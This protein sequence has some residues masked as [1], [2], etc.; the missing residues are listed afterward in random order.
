MQVFFYAVIYTEFCILIFDPYLKG[1]NEM[2]HR[3]L[4]VILLCI[5]PCASAQP[6][7][8]TRVFGSPAPGWEFVYSHDLGGP[9]N[10]FTVTS[11]NFQGFNGFEFDRPRDR[12]VMIGTETGSARLISVDP[13]FDPASQILLRTGLDESA[14]GVDVDPDTGRIYWWENDEILSVN[15]DGTGTPIVEADNVPEPLLLEID[16]SRGF[17]VMLDY[18]A[19]DLVVGQLNG[20]SSPA[21]TTVPDQLTGSV[22][23]FGF[24][25]DPIT[26]HIYWSEYQSPSGF[27]G[28]TS[29]IYRLPHDNLGATPQ[30]VFGT[31]IPTLSPAPFYYG[32]SVIDDQ[33][34][35]ITY[36]TIWAEF[37]A[38][39]LN[40]VNT[41]T[42]QV[43]VEPID[44]AFLDVELD[45]YVQPILQHPVGA[46]VDQGGGYVLEVIPSDEL[47][48]FQW[49]RNGNPVLDTS[50]ITGSTTS[51]LAITDAM[52]SDTDTYT[53]TVMAPNGDQQSSEEAIFAVRGSQEPE[54]I[55]DINGD[56]ELDFFDVSA[57]LQA[58]GIGCP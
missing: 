45:Y 36:S 35:T 30:L 2:I 53:C 51:K 1:M 54:C 14:I 55:P 23:R 46:V 50:R 9:L 12:V 10:S 18:P 57:F 16:A 21:P 31:E 24:A 56:G 37:S 22:T 17:Y 29:A 13:S 32:L 20:V 41:T 28:D 26:G 19:L 47:S 40:I 25:I 48:T 8:I 27:T 39:M 6:Y 52:L 7:S 15:S 33:L 58:F 4:A 5:V 49:F 43:S 42:N 38:P 11:P 34:A 44:L 3:L